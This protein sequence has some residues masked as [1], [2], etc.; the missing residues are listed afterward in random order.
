MSLLDRY[1]LVSATLEVLVTGCRFDSVYITTKEE[2]LG[3]AFY[4]QR[5]RF[6]LLPVDESE[7]FLLHRGSFDCLTLTVL[8]PSKSKQHRKDPNKILHQIL[9]LLGNWKLLTSEI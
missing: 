5:R 9:E 1:H 8:L 7:A 3:N 6:G 4:N 2:F